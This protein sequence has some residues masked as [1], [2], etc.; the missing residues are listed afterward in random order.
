M[1]NKER[2]ILEWIRRKDAAI[3]RCNDHF[4]QAHLRAQLTDLHRQL[5]EVRAAEAERAA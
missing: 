4:L 2:A 1:T 3:A 5:R